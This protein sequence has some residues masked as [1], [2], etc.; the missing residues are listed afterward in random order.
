M[1]YLDYAAHT[2][3]DERVLEAYC[4]VTRDFVGNPNSTHPL[5][6]AAKQKFDACTDRI[7]K[8]L[9]IKQ[10]EIIYTSGATESN[11]LAIKGIA[12]AY[13]KNGKHIITSYLEHSSVTGPIGK[14]GSLG[15]EIDFVD[16]TRGGM[17]DLEHLEEL[18]EEDTVLVSIGYIDSE[19]GLV[20]PIE[21]IGKL[22]KNYPNV[23]FHVDATQAVGKIPISIEN[24]D[25]MTFSAHK[26]YGMTGSGVLVRKEGIQL[27]PL[28]DGGISTTVYRSG[29]PALPLTASMSSALE[30]AYEEMQERYQLVTE[31]YQQLKKGLSMLEGLSINTGIHYSPFILNFSLKNKRSAQVQ[32]EL[33]QA[34]F[35]VSSKSACCAVQAP[36]RPV[37][38][39]TKNRKASTS[40]LRVGL[41]HLVTEKNIEDFIE[42][43][44][45]A[46]E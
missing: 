29:T 3:T 42:A 37:Y 25:L 16:I 10:E 39:L 7:A 12:G 38:A 28:L 21:E 23:F 41:S 22:L 6:Q 31:R 20:Q 32:E 13:K 8:L 33:A 26:F 17:I 18:I 24:I 40:T 15:Y 14:L 19:I 4:Q 34:G 2:P 9:K 5:G 27:E 44:S 36:S 11:N 43:L 30:I 45:K 46:L 1:I 35:C